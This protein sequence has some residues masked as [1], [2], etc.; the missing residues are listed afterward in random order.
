MSISCNCLKRPLLL[1]ADQACFHRKGKHH[2]HQLRLPLC[3]SA[4]GASIM[5]S[6]CDCLYPLLS[7]G[8]HHGHQQL[9]AGPPDGGWASISCNCPYL[10]A[11]AHHQHAESAGWASITC[12]S[13]NCFGNYFPLCTSGPS[14]AGLSIEKRSIMSISCDCLSPLLS[15]GVHH[16][17]Q[18]LV[19]NPLDGRAS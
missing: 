12:I 2:E 15:A 11:A 8:V 5:S 14:A 16:G 17:H 6:S 9:V 3:G 7:A 10:S 1:G 19:A 18:Q 4:G 13:C